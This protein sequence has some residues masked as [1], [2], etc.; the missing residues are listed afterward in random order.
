ME[1]RRVGPNSDQCIFVRG[2]RGLSATRFE[3][4]LERS[5]SRTLLRTHTHAFYVLELVPFPRP[6]RSRLESQQG[7]FVEVHEAVRAR[8]E[9]PANGGG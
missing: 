9:R 5:H 2:S 1:S 6:N 7:R 3:I 8:G 4:G